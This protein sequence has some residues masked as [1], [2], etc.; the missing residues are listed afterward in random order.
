V[1]VPEVVQRVRPLPG[2][3]ESYLSFAP[4]SIEWLTPRE[5]E[6]QSAPVLEYFVPN[7]VYRLSDRDDYV[8]LERL[9]D[10]CKLFFANASNINQRADGSYSEEFD[11]FGWGV[12][13][14]GHQ[15]LFSETGVEFDP[16]SHSLRSLS[17]DEIAET[18]ARI[19]ERPICLLS[20]EL[21]SDTRVDY[22]TLPDAKAVM[23]LSPTEYQSRLAQLL[24]QK[25]TP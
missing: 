7:A 8:E 1:V 21:L 4:S 25:Q 22:D 12:S 14:Y 17:E 19:A 13:A 20:Q 16:A 15:L 23:C 3:V 18:R 6:W 5:Q 11:C 2:P 9:G 24:N 10:R